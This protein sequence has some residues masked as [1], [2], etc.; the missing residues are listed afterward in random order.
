M[1]F[2]MSSR[3]VGRA[4]LTLIAC[5]LA[6]DLAVAV[7]AFGFGRDHLMGMRKLLDV[8]TE[9]SI[10]TW[11]SIVQ[12]TASSA[13]LAVIAASKRARM[14]RFAPYWWLLSAGFAY[15]SLDESVQLHEY[16]GA[17]VTKFITALIPL[18][19]FAWV[20]LGAA[21]AAAAFAL[22]FPFLRGLPQRFRH[23]FLWAGACYLGGALGVELL[24]GVY[25]I[26]TRARSFE[27]AVAHALE[28]G[29]EMAGIA[30]FISALLSY[31][32]SEM[33]EIS[34]RLGATPVAGAAR[35]SP[36]RRTP[37]RTPAHSI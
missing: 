2:R 22:F 34:I 3:Q 15:L 32:A 25:E 10:P 19:S 9:R 18:R 26:G 6:A 30:L 12:L 16:S 24:G 13:L 31:I 17:G 8:N 36:A 21:A 20:A 37:S 33:G 29:M 27:L 5:L 35:S 1:N 4:L 14:D 7:M 11:F 28:E 23:R